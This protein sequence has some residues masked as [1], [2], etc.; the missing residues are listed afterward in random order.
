MEITGFVDGFQTY[1]CRIQRLQVRRANHCTI[2][3]PWIK[4]TRIREPCW[5]VCEFS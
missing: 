1:A 5:W 3:S 4:I 2:A